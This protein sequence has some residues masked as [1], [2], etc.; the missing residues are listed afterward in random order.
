MRD[1]ILE[2]TEV[3][4]LR[5]AQADQR[6]AAARARVER[7]GG[8]LHVVSGDRPAFLVSRWCLTKKLADVDAVERW[9]AQVESRG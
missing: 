6:I 1:A 7:L 2:A 5:V 8:A 4:R 9:L 3:E